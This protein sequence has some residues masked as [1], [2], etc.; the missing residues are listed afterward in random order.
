[1]FNKIKN[2]FVEGTD[3]KAFQERNVIEAQARYG[4]LSYSHFAK[5]M[6]DREQK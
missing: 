4:G 2:L 5:Y 3:E 6:Q 1:M